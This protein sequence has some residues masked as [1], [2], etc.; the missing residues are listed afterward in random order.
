MKK[1]LLFL[2]MAS[3]LAPL[4]LADDIAPNPTQFPSY[5]PEFDYAAGKADPDSYIGEFSFS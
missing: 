1:L 5:Y 4:A 3:L 2:L